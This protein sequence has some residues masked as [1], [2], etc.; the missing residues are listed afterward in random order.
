MSK[1]VNIVHC[2]D[3]EGPLTESLSNTFQRLRNIYNIQLKPTKKNLEKIQLEKI[4]LNGLEKQIAN[5]FS[6]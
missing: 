2:I 3:T 5:T 6:K 1:I 4:N